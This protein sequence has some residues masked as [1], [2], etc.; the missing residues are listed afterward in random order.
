[1]LGKKVFFCELA[2]G[3]GVVKTG[4]VYSEMVSAGGY[5]KCMIYLPNGVRVGVE[6]PLVFETEQEAQAA[7]AKFLPIHIEMKKIDDENSAKLDALREQII[8][9]PK[10]KEVLNE[11][12]V[13]N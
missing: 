13:K 10:F 1:M 9:K 11:L 7:L 6:L 3:K 12:G 4:I 8:G 5:H 2:N